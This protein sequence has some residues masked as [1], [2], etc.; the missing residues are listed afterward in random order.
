MCAVTLTLGSAF[1]AAR[2]E[3]R[4]S[5]KDNER[6]REGERE[7]TAAARSHLRMMYSAATTALCLETSFLRNRN[8]RLRLLMSIVSVAG[9][10]SG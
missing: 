10:V 9:R 5:E 7:R 2:R 8:W 1:A 4:S 6:E 3:Q